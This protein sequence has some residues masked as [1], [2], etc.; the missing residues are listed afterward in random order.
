MLKVL[1]ADDEKNICL[2]IQKIISWK[3]YGMEVVGL[4]HNG[5]DA[6]R[7]IEEELPDV[8]IS[9]IR[10]PGYD[11]LELVQKTHDMG[12][13][14]DFVIISGYKYFE[15]AHKALNLGVEH[16][17]L[18][19]I[20]KKEL[21]EILFK[22]AKKRKLDVL[23]A[24]EE[25]ELKEQVRYNKR[26]IKQHFL[27]SI[28]ENR[29]TL[30]DLELNRVNTEFQCA[31]K[32]GCFVA[33]FAKIDSEEKEQD[34]SGLLH[35]IEGIIDH[36]MREDLKEYI[37][38]TM[39]SGIVTIVNYLDDTRED[40]RQ[41]TERVL[42]LI[43]KELDK[44]HGYHITIGV[45][46]EKYALAEI[47]DSIRES[48]AAVK[49]RGKAGIDKVIFYEKLHYREMP[50][51]DIF[52]ESHYR[53]Y[54]NITESLD[55]EAFQGECIKSYA[56]LKGMGF[57]S[58]VVFYEYLEK[59]LEVTKAVLK[60]NG[61]EE[62]E[63]RQFEEDLQKTLD[64]Y[65]D[66]DEMTYR[67]I[68][69]VRSHFEKMIAKRK[70]R[71]QLPIRMAKQYV[72]EHYSSQVSLEDVA[73]AIHLSPAYVSTLFKKEMGINFSDYLIFCRMEAAK[74]L[75]KTT[76]LSI[77]EAAEK[78]GYTDSRHFSKTFN[79]LVGIKPSAYRKL[80]R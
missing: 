3:D 8:V 37:N 63:L 52:D 62:E 24:K 36:E 23:K 20:D 60:K 68:E 10:M 39:K 30:H 76:D 6:F 9:D 26:R 40:V 54:E 4:V 16:Y 32:Q 78:V 42:H 73:E 38:S 56:K 67:F 43:K 69:Q 50:L 77:A 35:I 18:K 66:L 5:V 44:F 28:I 12:L 14:T 29:S 31:F 48:I 25:E 70:N 7:V 19:P 80:Y 55:Y 51:S 79:K 41:G 22:I 33:I 17:L 53:E 65:I 58:P 2:M 1:I 71:S 49:C 15:Y 46:R 21:E 57:V 75:L 11:G 59:L 74:E 47:S 13:E 27:S 61:V 45:G 34:L 64:F 72:Q